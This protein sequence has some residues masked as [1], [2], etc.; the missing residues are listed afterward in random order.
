MF[1]LCYNWLL[2]CILSEGSFSGPSIFNPQAL[3]GTRER[4]RGRS[5]PG[6]PC[7]QSLQCSLQHE[8]QAQHIWEAPVAAICFP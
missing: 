4:L 2:T 5:P 1:G 7:F 6:K 8:R 3:D